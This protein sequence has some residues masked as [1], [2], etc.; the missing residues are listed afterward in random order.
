MGRVH[1]CTPSWEVPNGHVAVHTGGR[2]PKLDGSDDRTVG[3]GS[4]GGERN[5]KGRREKAIDGRRRTPPRS[6]RRC[7]AV[8]ASLPE[9][10]P[11]R[12]FG[13]WRP[14]PQLHTGRQ[15]RTRTE[16][17][18]LTARDSG[19]QFTRRP[20]PPFGSLLLRRRRIEAI[21]SDF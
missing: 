2:T 20:I 17:E 1:P 3:V 12:T 6:G 5:E 16:T 9:S 11:A 13:V 4:H 7:G 15:R 18:R 21:P 19:V 8:C 14:G 10:S